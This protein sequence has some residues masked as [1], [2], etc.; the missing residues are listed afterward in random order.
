[1]QN[2]AELYWTELDNTGQYWTILDYTDYTRLYWTILGHTR[3]KQK[4]LR[5]YWTLHDDTGL[6]LI[7]A[8]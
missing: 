8:Q 7:N 6:Y 5:L 1:M 3:L 2:Y 4:I